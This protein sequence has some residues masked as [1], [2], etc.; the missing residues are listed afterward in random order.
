MSFKERAQAAAST[1]AAWLIYSVGGSGVLAIIVA[2]S[3]ALLWLRNSH[4]LDRFRPAAVVIP[5][6]K[7]VTITIK[8]SSIIIRGDQIVFRAIVQGPAGAP[9]WKLSP[10]RASALA[11]EE[12]GRTAIF[13][14]TEP[15]KYTL[16]ASVAGEA[17]TV[18]TDYWEF[19]V[20]DAT[21][22]VDDPLTVPQYDPDAPPNPADM[23]AEEPLHVPT[24]A[25]MVLDSLQHVES[26]NRASEARVIAGSFQSVA[27][28]IAAGLVPPDADPFGLVEEQARAA[29]GD[30]KADEWALFFAGVRS[31][32]QA[33]RDQGD[34]STAASAI[35]TLAETAEVL[36]RA[37]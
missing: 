11:V 22:Q 30:D 1:A 3:V 32:A 26:P 7:P 13:H 27:N 25:E 37:R 29:L 24:V 9:A 5:E 34:I 15:G 28:R 4:V 17:K 19:E 8:G 2:V 33:L 6:A 16:T 23:Q 20:V 35:P 14:A 31:I 21:E 36:L 12:D 18:A 10:S